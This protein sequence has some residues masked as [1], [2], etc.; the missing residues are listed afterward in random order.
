MTKLIVSHTKMMLCGLAVY[1][2]CALYS[3]K[4]KPG[5][6]IRSAELYYKMDLF[7]T[8]DRQLVVFSD[9]IKIFEREGTVLYL[10]TTPFEKTKVELD[11]AGD[12]KSENLLH[13]GVRHSYIF[14]RDDSKIGLLFDTMDVTAYRIVN[15][16][17]NLKQ[18]LFFNEEMFYNNNDSLLSV[19]K[20]ES[21]VAEVYKPR[22][23]PDDSYPDSSILY[24]T[25][26]NQAG[27]CYSLTPSL[28]SIRQ[29]KLTKAV[30]IYKRRPA[31]ESAGYEIPRRETVFE[32]REYNKKMEGLSDFFDRAEKI[33][34]EMPGN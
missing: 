12:I 29:M 14:K 30:F 25:A 27:I 3:C 4:V 8:Q 19:S 10:I 31:G 1:A 28:D 2:V 7:K 26:K 24:F 16:D 20:T 21:L 32:I 6:E 13:S 9:S 18:K 11:S 15:A 34:K 17:S 33:L 5:A 23:Q 22:F